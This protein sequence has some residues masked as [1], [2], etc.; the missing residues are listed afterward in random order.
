V[1]KARDEQT[2]LSTKKD[3]LLAD[4][5]RIDARLAELDT[6]L[7]VANGYAA[8]VMHDAA[9]ELQGN[10]TV[11][12]DAPVVRAPGGNG[13]LPAEQL[14]KRGAQRLLVE[15][16]LRQNR[17][18]GLTKSG[19]GQW[20]EAEYSKRLTPNSVGVTLDRLKKTTPPLARLEG[21]R[22]VWI[23]EDKSSAADHHESAAQT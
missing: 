8:A 18:Q 12:A 19:I 7:R 23:G 16:A 17:P 9:A 5:A 10:F 14:Q 21:N 22:W 13:H 1:R 20:I 15:E 11:V 2:S 3:N 6:F 4:V